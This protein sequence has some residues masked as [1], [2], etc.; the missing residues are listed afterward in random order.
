MEDLT[1]QKLKELSIEGSNEIKFGTNKYTVK[2]E[3]L[4]L[5]KRTIDS[6]LGNL[7]EIKNNYYKNNDDKMH[8]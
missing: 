2:S 8:E 7:E 5:L 1:Q 3:A 6:E 4:I